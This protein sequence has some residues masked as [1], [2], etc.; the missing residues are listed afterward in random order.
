MS[1]TTR[2]SYITSQDG[3]EP[4]KRLLWRSG[5]AVRKKSRD[6]RIRMQPDEEV[7]IVLPD[8]SQSESL[9]FDPIGTP[10]QAQAPALLGVYRCSLRAAKRYRFSSAQCG[11]LMTMSWSS[12]S[13]A[14]GLLPAGGGA[15]A[16]RR[17]HD[18]FL[19]SQ[20]E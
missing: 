11:H 17:P 10:R 14:A 5:A 9:G 13:A 2:G 6:F 20:P 1:E 18:L 3:L 12:A 8:P 7:E 19:Q 15:M 4:A 16:M